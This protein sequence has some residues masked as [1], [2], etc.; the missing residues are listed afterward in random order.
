MMLK[1][2][3]DYECGET[4]GRGAFGIVRKVK[5]KDD[6]REYAVKILD[7]ATLRQEELAVSVAKEILF[8]EEL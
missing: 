1:M 8:M 6:K 7:K 5:H 4:L 2:I 3:G